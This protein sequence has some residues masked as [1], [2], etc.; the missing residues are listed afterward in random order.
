MESEHGRGENCTT[1]WPVIAPKKRDSQKQWIVGVYRDTYFLL[2]AMEISKAKSAKVVATAGPLPY[3]Q[4]WDALNAMKMP[5]NKWWL[6]GH[7][8]RYA[9][10]RAR[11]LE[12]L[13]S[14]KIKLPSRKK[15]DCEHQRSGK[16]AF[17]QNCLEIDV[18]CQCNKLKILD[19]RNF[20][21]EPEIDPGDAE[22]LAAWRAQ[23]TLT[24]YLAYAECAS[25]S[26]SRTTSAQ[27]GWARFRTRNMPSVLCYNR[28]YTDRELERRAYFGG[29]N[30]PYRLGDIEGNVYS[31][32]IKSC[33]AA[34]CQNCDVPITLDEVYPLG[35]PVED[36]DPASPFHWIADCVIST[37][38][39]DY[40]LRHGGLPVYP[41]GTFA[42]SLAWPELRHALQNGRIEKIMRAQRY[43]T[44]YAFRGLANWYFASRAKLAA[45]EQAH[46]MP[47]LKATFNAALGYS[48]RR[49][50][51]LLPWDIDLLEKWWVGVTSAPDHSAPV[52]HAQILD[53][54]KEWLRIGGEPREAMPFLH[55]TITSW[56]RM[57][58]MSVMSWAGKQNVLYCDTDGLLV[59]Y[60]GYA[61]LLDSP[62]IMGDAP[63][64]LTE[65]HQSGPCRIQGQK[66][67]K[68]G[69][70]VVCAGLVQTRHSNWAQ[71]SVLSTPTGRSNFEGEVTP[72]EFRCEDA[73][74]E[75]GRYINE[76]L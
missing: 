40:P 74:D 8:T 2:V 60:M 70:V 48:A 68:I 45:T 43:S 12:H 6:I 38:S 65:R 20:G 53:G 47:C 4:F 64:Q 57:Q 10:E 41:T 32:D 1:N 27:I 59:N 75:K 54:V 16:L 46:L 49:K 31:L 44:D 3:D 15:K 30:E 11:F 37:T 67:Y 18:Q 50:Y 73:G 5:R 71:K 51:E 72:Y 69:D 42:T 29:R 35:M 55:A 9:L 17:S 26:V 22:E 21:I 61:N 28:N 52:V 62:G 39:P 24:D 76:M 36:L 13:E 58:L 66:N 33:Y 19:W 23:K 25:V 63:G 7:R 34:I 14:G 56:A